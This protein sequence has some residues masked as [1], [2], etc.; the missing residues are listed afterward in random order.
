MVNTSFVRLAIIGINCWFLLGSCHYKEIASADYPPSILY[1]PTARN[2][3]FVINSISTTGTYQFSVDLNARQV[4][5]PLGVYRG[6][7]STEG[8]LLV[9]IKTNADTVGQLIRSGVLGQT[10]LLPVDKLVLPESV[11]IKSGSNSAVFNLNLNLDYLLATPQQKLA[12]GVGIESAQTLINPLLK[13]TLVSFDP[14]ILR[15]TPN[16]TAMADASNPRRITF[17]NT[18]LNSLNYTWDFGDG[19]TILSETAPTYTYAKAGTY[20]VLLTAT[21]VTGSAY[22]VKKTMTLTIP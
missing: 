18:S 11:T 9:G 10:A 19:S 12:I 16:F 3:L 13:T 20:T 2:G 1:M 5:I 7:V 6:G 15:P 14:S 17:T 8:D 21:G 4:V 22:A